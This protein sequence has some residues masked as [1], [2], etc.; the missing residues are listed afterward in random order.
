MSVQFTIIN[1][2]TLSMNKFWGETERVRPATAT[3]VLL[4]SEGRRLLVDPSPGPDERRPVPR[5]PENPPRPKIADRPYLMPL[6][7]K[8][9]AKTQSDHQISGRLDVI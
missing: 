7:R 5:F 2:G 6:F 4:E 9:V 8:I 1:L 3:C